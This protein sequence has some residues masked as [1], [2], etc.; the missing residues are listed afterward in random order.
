MRPKTFL[1]TVP[2]LLA[3]MLVFSGCAAPAAGPPEFVRQE[4]VIG[5]SGGIA[6]I[7]TPE[8]SAAPSPTPP[9]ATA[10]PAPEQARAL[11]AE[12]VY[13]RFMLTSVLDYIP[14]DTYEKNDDAH[15]YDIITADPEKAYSL[16]NAYGEWL[17]AASDNLI[18]MELRN[19]KTNFTAPSWQL[20]ST[21]AYAYAG[22]P[23]M[24]AQ[25]LGSACDFD[26]ALDPIAGGSSVTID[27]TPKTPSDLF[28]SLPETEYTTPMGNLFSYAYLAT[29]YDNS[30]EVRDGI[31]PRELEPLLFPIADPEERYFD[32]TWYASRDGGARRHTGTDINAPEGTDLLACVDGVIHD[33]G[34]GPG[35]GNYI[36]V[37][38]SDGTQYHYY[39][40]VE[41]P[42]LKAGDK[43]ER[44]D[45]VG[46]VGNTGNST[47]NHLHFTII[48]S[49][50]YYLNP[51][52]YLIESQT[53]TIAANGAADV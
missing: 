15:P 27:C 18:S 8:A 33:A 28:Y 43:V 50:G 23:E 4:T 3:V 30:M 26:I 39:H 5:P 13:D 38:A 14:A 31:A 48:T 45:V 10:S 20:L 2:L 41:P 49:D 11:T 47:A 12:E 42:A 19:V 29:I 36:V 53:E 44:G 7:E 24:M 16:V 22:D 51:Y 1:I 6:T 46:H 35:T 32:D 40:M 52:Q 25:A 34:S 17:K 9:E 37:M 21:I